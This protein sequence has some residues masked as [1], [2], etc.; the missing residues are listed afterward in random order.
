MALTNE[1]LTIGGRIIKLP[2][3]KRSLAGRNYIIR[4][5]QHFNEQVNVPE[6][7]PGAAYSVASNAVSTIN[8]AKAARRVVFSQNH[9]FATKEDSEANLDIATITDGTQ[10]VK[11]DSKEKLSDKDSK[12][13]YS[14]HHIFAA[15]SDSEA[16]HDTAP[17]KDVTKHGTTQNEETPSNRDAKYGYS[18]EIFDITNESRN[19]VPRK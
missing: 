14:Q 5:E 13:A 16:N 11:S 18:A 8:D 19:S 15:N 17:V 7:Q 10:Y 4:G 9:V 2:Q 1:G 3:T 12:Y 6:H